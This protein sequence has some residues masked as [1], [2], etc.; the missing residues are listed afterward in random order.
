MARED[1]GRARQH[2]E[3]CLSVA[4]RTRSRR[5]VVRATRLLGACHAAA[6]N[7]RE[8]EHLLANVVTQA[9]RLANPTQLWQALLAHGRAQHALGRREDAARR[10]GE[11]LELVNRVAD[12]LPPEIQS[13]FRSSTVYTGLQELT[14]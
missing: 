13:V 10:A 14:Q 6:G 4:Q 3:N 2:I 5:Y 8:S 11:G 7:H 1:L 9:R 12:T